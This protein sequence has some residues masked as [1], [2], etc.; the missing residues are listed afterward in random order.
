MPQSSERSLRA[1]PSDWRKRL[2]AIL[3]DPNVTEPQLIPYS[4]IRRK[5]VFI[6]LSLVPIAL[7]VFPALAYVL[8]TVLGLQGYILF[9]L[10]FP[11][12]NLDPNQSF[13]VPPAFLQAFRIA[14]WIT[15]TIVYF[16]VFVLVAAI[17]LYAGLLYGMVSKL[18]RMEWKVSN[19][20]RVQFCREQVTPQYCF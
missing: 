15:D 19:E 3:S 12:F 14:E 2:L 8:P 10:V 18:Y 4:T 16:F 9:H 11:Y 17:L 1:I 7:V 13:S 20:T 6:L 5:Q